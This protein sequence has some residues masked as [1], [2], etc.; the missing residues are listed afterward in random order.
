MKPV[1]CLLS[2]LFLSAL[3]LCSRDFQSELERLT[4]HI[5]LQ[6]NKLIRTDSVTVK[7]NERQ[8]DT[9]ALIIY[10]YSKGDKIEILYARIEDERG[11]VIRKLKKNEIEDRSYI[12]DISLYEDD[13]VKSFELRHNTY[14]YYVKYAVKSTF[15]KYLQLFSYIPG[16]TTPPVRQA[17]VRVDTSDENPIRFRMKNIESP[18]TET[19]GKRTTYTWTFHYKPPGEEQFYADRESTPLPELQIY[20][21]RFK[22]G[23]EGSWETWET[24]GE[25][26]CRLNRGRD[27]LP[28]SEKIAVNRL[29]IGVTEAE[30]KAR[31]LYR[32]LQENTRYINVKIDVGGFQAYPAR[33][34]CENRY[35]DC[36]ALSNYMQA[37]L[38]YAGIPSFYTL[39]RAGE[40]VEMFDPS[41]PS[42]LFNHVIL[43]LPLGSDT[44]FLECTS[45]DIPF[46]Y[47]HTAI[48]GRKAMVVAEKG[49]RLIDLPQM[50]PDEVLCRRKISVRDDRIEMQLTLRGNE[51]ERLNYIR[52]NL[53]KSEMERYLRESYLRVGNPVLTAYSIDDL[54]EGTGI[55]LD[56]SLQAD[57]LF[58]RYGNHIALT[59]F[60]LPVTA[61]ERPEARHFPVRID[62][63]L[64]R[65]DEISY[66]LKNDSPIDIPEAISLATPFGSYS[67]EYSLS[68]GKLL[69]KKSLSLYA[70]RYDL[71]SYPAFYAFMRSVRGW[72]NQ[73]L[74]IESTE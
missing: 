14:P 18:L 44:V 46:G 24:F 62:L 4:V 5:V 25:W 48:Q 20:P 23:A 13:F 9:D 33:Y 64:K 37:L 40:R 29:L 32:Y 17:T 12:S 8:G 70:G 63:P 45:K 28:E 7:I 41:F 42:Q 47:T 59:P 52:K 54:P 66:D 51:Y 35:G 36:K 15:F 21:L 43:T 61:F 60:P 58:K 11:N 16:Y 39:V 69:L 50:T 2:A 55:L 30:E 26:I 56:I 72:E 53:N 57:Q 34:V 65:E 3:P 49:S 68:D 74:T 31:I 38:K 1:I 19:E 67:Q 73:K 6:G 71:E 27:E 10:P 22:Y